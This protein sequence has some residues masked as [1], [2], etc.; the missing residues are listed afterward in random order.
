M[1]STVRY[2][3]KDRGRAGLPPDTAALVDEIRPDGAGIQ[4]VNTNHGETRRVIVQAGAFGEHDFTEV[5]HS[6]VRATTATPSCL[7]TARPSSSSCLLRPRS[8]SMPGMN[9]YVNK[10]SYAFPW[11][12]ES[13]PIPFH[14]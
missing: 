7:C 1:R 9:R 4:L 3:D 12:G 10:P 6:T 14:E 8:A 13:I 11:H 5:S 2:F